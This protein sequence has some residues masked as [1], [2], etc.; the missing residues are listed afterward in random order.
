MSCAKKMSACLAEA[1]T[2]V[3]IGGVLCFDN[4]CTL[5]SSLHAAGS[6]DGNAG[7]PRAIL[8]GRSP[9]GRNR[10]FLS[11]LLKVDAQTER[12]WVGCASFRCA[13]RQRLTATRHMHATGR[14]ALRVLETLHFVLLRP[15][16][17]CA[18]R[19]GRSGAECRSA[20]RA[21]SRCLPANLGMRAPA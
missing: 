9:R 11:S 15:E 13:S 6:F 12:R 3:L 16:D 19:A 21:F 1:D 8:G 17:S 7:R 5:R 20:W 4:P 10:H 18:D 14:R 2:V